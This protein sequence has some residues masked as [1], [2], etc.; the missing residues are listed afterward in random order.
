MGFVMRREQRNR[1]EG[2]FTL[3]ELLVVLVILGLLA[4]IVGPRVLGYI[5]GARTDSARL[6]IENFKSALDLYLINTGS[7]P[8]T[9]EGL[10][11]LVARPPGS[12]GWAG[13]YLRAGALPADPWGSPYQYRA[14]GQHGAYDL[15]S[16]GADRAEGGSDDAADI[17]S[18]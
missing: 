11:A 1:R 7:Y 16:L 2:G 5:G 9:S 12:T 3:I 8:A 6:Q 10:Q 4:G 13:P 17:T 15:W 18:W 14:P